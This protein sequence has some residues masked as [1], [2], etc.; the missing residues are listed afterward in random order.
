MDCKDIQGRV[1][2]VYK[3]VGDVSKPGV[4]INGDM[5]NQSQ[6]V[7][8][9]LQGAYYNATGMACTD[10]SYSDHQRMY[11]T[12]VFLIFPSTLPATVEVSFLKGRSSPFR[13]HLTL[14]PS[15][16]TTLIKQ[17]NT[18]YVAESLHTVPKF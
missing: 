2:C 8:L 18:P 4:F 14:V 11:Y 10:E 16:N 13:D 7:E 5:A 15:Y 17:G 6:Y 1:L 12:G 9:Q 3:C